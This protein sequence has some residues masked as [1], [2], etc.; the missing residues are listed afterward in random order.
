MLIVILSGKTLLQIQ[1]KRKDK[2][3]ILVFCTKA[4]YETEK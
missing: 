4:G 1:V 3:A 2:S